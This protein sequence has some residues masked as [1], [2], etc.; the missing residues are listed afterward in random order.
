MK[1]LYH[2]LKQKHLLIQKPDKE[3]AAVLPEKYS[4]ANSM[5][6]TILNEN[7]FELINIKEDKQHNFILKNEK[8]SCISNK[9]FK[10]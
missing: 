9:T 7:K 2:L 10:E 3:N 8:K 4:Y 1:I 6:E 5:K